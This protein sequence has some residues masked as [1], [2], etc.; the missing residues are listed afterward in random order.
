[1]PALPAAS[2]DSESDDVNDESGGVTDESDDAIDGEA[3]EGSGDG[4]TRELVERDLADK[5]DFVAGLTEDDLDSGAWFPML[6]AHA[7]STY[8]EKV[9]YRYFQDKYKGIPPDAIVEKRIKLAASYAGLEGSISSGLY[10][11]YMASK[12]GPRSGAPKQKTAAAI[13]AAVMADVA[14]LTTLQLRLAYD[15]AVLYRVTLDL[16]DPD[17][18]W[19][20]I[21]VALTIRSG[22]IVRDGSLK[23]VP[24]IVRPL[25]KK[26]YAGPVLSAAKGLPV[27]GKYL[28][29]RNVIKVA[30]PVV[31][32]PVAFCIN[33]WS[34]IVVG[35]HART[36]FRNDAEVIETAQKLVARTEHPALMLWVAWFVV[37][38]DGKTT[39]NEALLMRH[40]ARLLRDSYDIDDDDLAR[41]IEFD[42][43]DVWCRLEADTGNT[44]DLLELATR[45]ATVDGPINEREGAAIAQLGERCVA[46]GWTPHESSPV[47]RA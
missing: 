10:S 40:I 4:A 26:Y 31:S 32:V 25:M 21:R 37:R 47:D 30:I 44:G 16:A 33:R 20:L 36:V 42:P 5:R 7:L 1:M 38:A 15:I 27:V 28:L 2:G 18:L 46:A 9:D 17:D 11:A 8:T 39:D 13:S 41:T 35:N 12:L 34:T 6:I 14:S 43:N 29:Q 45:V 24:Q 19:K 22:A 3:C 23:L